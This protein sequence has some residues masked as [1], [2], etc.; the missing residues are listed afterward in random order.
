PFSQKEIRWE[1]HAIE[2]RINAE[3]PDRNFAPSA[4]RIEK[5][6]LPGGYGVRVDTHICAGYE[7][8]PYYDPLLAKVIVWDKT[9]AGAINRM[10]RCLSEMEIT[11]VKTNI[12]F[13]L[14][15]INNAFY[16]RGEVSTDFIQR[17]ILSESG[18]NGV[19]P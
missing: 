11:G 9:R 1:G 2:C 6:I 17:R 19:N 8:P 14:K 12:G 16:R 7:V 5:V 13:Q 4:G 18:A 3:D 15:I 10:Q